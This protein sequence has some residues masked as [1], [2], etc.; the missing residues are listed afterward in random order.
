MAKT[1]NKILFIGGAMHGRRIGCGEYHS[2]GYDQSVAKKTGFFW[3]HYT[4]REL[5]DGRR[6]YAFVWEGRCDG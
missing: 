6:Y 1:T 2:Y 3:H 4:L 5:S